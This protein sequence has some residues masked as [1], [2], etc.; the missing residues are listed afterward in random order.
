MAG[1]CLPPREFLVRIASRLSCPR[2][3]RVAPRVGR[4]TISTFSYIWISIYVAR[5]FYF[6]PFAY[7]VPPPGRKTDPAHAISYLA[8]LTIRCLVFRIET[9]SL[10]FCRV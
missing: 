3:R 6:V 7:L 5:L 4:P 1:R 9:R 10:E 8:L 2:L